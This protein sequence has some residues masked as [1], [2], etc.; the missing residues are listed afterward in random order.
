MTD[1]FEAA[2]AELHHLPVI[3][4]ILARLALELGS[5]LVYHTVEHT[6]EVL[7][8]TV[9]FAL[10]DGLEAR[11]IEL[12]AI[13]AAYHDAGYLERYADNEPIGAAMAAEAMRA[14]GGYSES[15][16]AL[17]GKMIL[18]TK[19][20]EGPDS[21]RRVEHDPLALYLMDADFGS[22]GREDFFE[23]CQQLIDETGT[24]PRNFYPIAQRLVSGQ[25]W[26]T[27]AAH[28]L[29]EPKKQQNLAELEQKIQALD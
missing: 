6:R 29:R 25:R 19:L 21:A 12:L 16:I 4:R 13:A 5:N 15:D 14:A 8:E 3:R 9:N 17:V 10:H 7:A 26:L 23:K 2:L 20:A 24:A 27:P 11:Q 22:F 28:A 1:T 18:S